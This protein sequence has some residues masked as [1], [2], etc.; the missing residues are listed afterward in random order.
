MRSH[1]LKLSLPR[2]SPRRD[3]SDVLVRSYVRLDGGDEP[4]A[5]VGRGADGLKGNEA[6]RLG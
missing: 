2:R 5:L 1:D 6:G 4:H 3:F